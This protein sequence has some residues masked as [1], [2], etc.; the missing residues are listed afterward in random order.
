MTPQHAAGVSLFLGAS[1]LAWSAYT[2]KKQYEKQ[3]AL[4]AQIAEVREREERS[5]P[6]VRFA[7][8]DT[9]LNLR[10]R[11]VSAEI[12]YRQRLSV[13]SPSLVTLPDRHA[14][15]PRTAAEMPLSTVSVTSESSKE[16]AGQATPARCLSAPT[17]RPLSPKP[18]ELIDHDPSAIV[19]PVLDHSKGVD[20]S[21]ETQFFAYTLGQGLFRNGPRDPDDDPDLGSLVT[22]P[23]M[24]TTTQGVGRGLTSRWRPPQRR[25]AITFKRQQK[26]GVDVRPIDTCKSDFS[27]VLLCTDDAQIPLACTTALSLRKEGTS[28]SIVCLLAIQGDLPPQRRLL[29]Q[30]HMD[31]IIQ[32]RTLAEQTPL[33]Q[34]LSSRPQLALLLLWKLPRW[35]CVY[36]NNHCLAIRCAD[37]LFHTGTEFAAVQ[38]LGEPALDVSVF[39]AKPSSQTFLRLVNM[40]VAS[41]D[42]D[43]ATLLNT[44]LSSA[45]HLSR[46]VVEGDVPERFCRLS[47]LYNFTRQRLAR[48][49]ILP[50]V[51]IFNFSSSLLAWLESGAPE[52]LPPVVAKL[53]AKWSVLHAIIDPELPPGA[54]DVTRSAGAHG[55]VT[56]PYESA[57]WAPTP[58]AVEEVVSADHRAEKIKPTTETYGC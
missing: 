54:G 21:D 11:S 56:R 34:L 17:R 37:T 38:A 27:F 30:L 45:S 44:Y 15:P 22:S 35:R 5:R 41:P 51:K 19:H 48:D 46:A 3:R 55:D 16:Q 14:S 33:H 12:E 1:F 23:S 50:S 9:V 13:V 6:R 2:S 53:F 7:Q 28:A 47:V 36:V 8:S 25:K 32:S 52:D 42:A 20:E 4:S 40:A 18:G 39:S 24:S 49:S 10:R 29:L 31:E 26:F 58:R 57:P 43:V